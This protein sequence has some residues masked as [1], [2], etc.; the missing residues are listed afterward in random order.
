MATIR[1]KGPEQW[2]AQV[3]RTGWARSRPRL[4]SRS[5]E[6]N[7]RRDHLLLRIIAF[8]RPDLAVSGVVHTATMAVSSRCA[9][10]PPRHISALR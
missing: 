9:F 8:A 3:R 1:Q 6:S 2:H 4:S 5:H 7:R 10:V